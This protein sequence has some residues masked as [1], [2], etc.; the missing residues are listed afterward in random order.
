MIRSN[1]CPLKD[2]PTDKTIPLASFFIGLVFINVTHAAEIPSEKNRPFPNSPHNLYNA[3]LRDASTLDNDLTNHYQK[4]CKQQK[5]P[6]T[7]DFKIEPGVDLLGGLKEII[8]KK[9]DEDE[10]ARLKKIKQDE[11]DNISDFEGLNNQFQDDLDVISNGEDELTDDEAKRILLGQES[12]EKSMESY[13]K[14]LEMNKNKEELIKKAGIASRETIPPLLGLGLGT[15][16][17]FGGMALI[18]TTGF[19][20]PVVGPV[21]TAVGIGV[22]AGLGTWAGLRGSIPER[23]EEIPRRTVEFFEDLFKQT[24][25]ATAGEIIED[26]HLIINEK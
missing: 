10:A 25:P 9:E 8:K 13:E 14:K 5:M 22:L 2:K 20:I 21:V 4:N 23:F 19:S 24:E 11:L 7:I 1:K 6:D 3:P 16:A 26:F 12:L 15:G 17:G 18:T